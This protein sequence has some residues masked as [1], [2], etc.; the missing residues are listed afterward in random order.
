MSETI[1]A[2][3]PSFNRRDLLRECLQALSNQTRPVEVIW[4]LDNASNDGTAQMI[5]AEFP[6]VRLAVGQENLGSSGGFAEGLKAAYAGGADWIWIVDN[7]AM[8]RPDALEAL[9]QARDHLARAGYSLGGLGSIA[10]WTDDHLHPMN[11]ALPDWKWR[12]HA[13]RLN[14]LGCEAVRWLSFV[15]AL[16]PR[17][18]VERYGVPFYSYFTLNDDLEYFGRIAKK[19]L[20]VLV[21]NSLVVHKTLDKSIP[22]QLPSERYFFDVRNRIWVLRGNSFNLGE[23]AWLLGHFLGQMRHHIFSDK[24]HKWQVLVRGLREGFTTLPHH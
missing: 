9:L 12:G 11:R 13:A 21:K 15:S 16:V 20:L 7:D 1:W 19:E 22:A 18:V 6:Q 14:G 10:Y 24:P 4:V 2:V 17:H 8:A 3:I 5:E 23:K